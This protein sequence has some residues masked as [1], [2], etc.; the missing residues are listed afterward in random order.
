M[1][2]S[3][4]EIS[5]SPEM[6]PLP[7]IA[8]CI[9]VTMSTMCMFNMWPLI[10]ARQSIKAIRATGAGA[11]RMCWQNHTHTHQRTLS[12]FSVIAINQQFLRYDWQG[13]GRWCPVTDWSPGWCG[14]LQLTCDSSKLQV[15]DRIL[16]HL[17][18]FFIFIVLF[19][20]L[21]FTY[22][23]FFMYYN[24]YWTVIKYYRLMALSRITLWWNYHV[25]SS[26]KICCF[27]DSRI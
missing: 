13:W 5:A 9:C 10:T 4:S 2:S 21:I 20:L 6:P 22:W 19:Y 23:L 26:T 12:T 18:V 17:D 8:A 11:R 1:L 24:K 25:V 15:S 7:Q 27:N 3:Q 14:Q 16:H